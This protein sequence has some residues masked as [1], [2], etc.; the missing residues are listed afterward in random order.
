MALFTRYNLVLI[1]LGTILLSLFSSSP[2]AHAAT[3]VTFDSGT[4]PNQLANTLS[5]QGTLT[6]T[7][8]DVMVAFLTTF[9][10]AGTP[11]ITDSQLNTW[12]KLR[13]TDVATAVRESIWVTT[14]SSSSSDTVTG[15]S[16]AL[17]FMTLAVAA[18]KNVI[19]QPTNAR[20]SFDIDTVA[21]TSPRSETNSIYPLFAR[22]GLLIFSM[23]V[24]QPAAPCVEP[25]S[26]TVPSTAILRGQSGPALGGCANDLVP[27]YLADFQTT[28][29]P[30]APYTITATWST[31]TTNGKY[32]IL[33]LDPIITPRTASQNVDNA[34]VSGTN[35]LSI[36][37]TIGMIDL[38]FISLILV[39]SLFAGSLP[40]STV[41]TFGIGILVTVVFA[42][43]VLAVV[44]SFDSV[45]R[46]QGN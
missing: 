20:T 43:L 12:V 10:Q 23:A 31:P 30:G 8:K 11:G 36:I 1:F 15:T 13:D 18:Y 25:Y 28:F 35:L 33:E 44:G 19:A 41:L 40:V 2:T 16:S 42:V 22:N 4:F 32:M 14:T 9:D 45:F 21:F 17:T 6:T 29:A 38:I 37:V 46:A 3:L 24:Q 5:I 27:M 26:V 34:V 39:S 7:A